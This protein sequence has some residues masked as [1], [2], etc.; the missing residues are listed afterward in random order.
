MYTARFML[1][2]LASVSLLAVSACSSSSSTTTGT[3]AGGGGGGG[4][5][6]N[7]CTAADFA[8]HDLSA[9][10]ANRTIT[11]P[12][13]AAPAQYSPACITIAVG[14]SVTWTGAFGSHPL[15]QFGGDASMWITSTTSG[16]TATFSFPVGGTYGFHCSA[17]PSVM[18]GAVFVK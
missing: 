4:E 1:V 9:Q 11:F 10:S 15:E 3:D 5:T 17:H 6:V 13:G 14:Q 7:G 16:T 12:S 18:Q 8:A 2:T